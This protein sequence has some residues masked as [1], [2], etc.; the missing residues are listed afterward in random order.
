[1]V[2][3][4]IKPISGYISAHE[5]IRSKII[6]AYERLFENTTYIL[7]EKLSQYFPNCL[8]DQLSQLAAISQT[9]KV[10]EV[11]SLPHMKDYLKTQI[12]NLSKSFRNIS[13]IG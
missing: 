7:I 10:S 13:L 2:N 12:I 3:W 9:T 1:M 8:I 4:P 5:G 6:P 11:K